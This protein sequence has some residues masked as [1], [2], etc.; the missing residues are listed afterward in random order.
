M[1]PRL[2]GS[3]VFS[4]G[5]LRIAL[6]LA[7]VCSLALPA[8]AMAAMILPSDPAPVTPQ[9]DLNDVRGPVGVSLP[10]RTPLRS[11]ASGDNRVDSLL[12][13]SMLNA[14][15]PLTSVKTITYSFY[16]DDVFHGAYYGDETGVREVSEGV[17][18]NV[19]AIF[20]WYSSI[21]NVDYVEVAETS[22]VVGNFRIMLS[23]GSVSE[24]IGYAY[25]Y[26]PWSSDPFSRSSDVHLN[27]EF[28]Y[29]DADNTNGFQNPAGSHG[30][31]SLAHEI[32][33]GMGLKH[34]FSGSP[35]L[36]TADDNTA[37]TIMSYSFVGWPSSTPM[38]YDVAALQRMY[39]ARVK[40]AGDD[41]YGFTSVGT[42]QYTLGLDTWQNSPNL[43]KQTIWDSAGFDTLDASALPL[44]A[45]GYKFDLNGGG[46][47]V[48]QAIET[49][50]TATDP[51]PGK[52]YFWHGSSLAFAFAPERIVNSS[53]NDRIIANDSANTF[54]GYTAGTSVGNDRIE[55]ASSADKLDLTAYSE[56]AVSKTTNG[57]DLV[58]GLGA[59]GSV[60]LVDYYNGSMPAIKYSGAAANQV[61][62]ARISSSAT[63]GVASL[64]VSFDGS[65]S[66]DPDGSIQ[67]WAWSFSDGTS[68]S[69]V[70]T[71]KAYA[72]SGSYTATLTV[73]DNDGAKAS[74]ATIISVIQPSGTLA[75]MI[76]SSGLPLSGVT[77]SVAGRT[78]TTDGLGAYSVGSIPA[79]T[80][81]VTFAKSGYATQ[82]ASV[83]ISHLQTTTRSVSLVL[84]IGTLSG[85][86]KY[87]T[88]PVEGVSV[89][90]A[91]LTTSTAADG[92]YSI[93]SIPK[94]ASAAT[95][96]KTGYVT[97]T[98]TVTISTGAIL[99][100]NV[101]LSHEVGVLSGTVTSGGQPVAG[102]SVSVPGK[103]SVFTN[104]SGVYTITG[105]NTGSY[106]ATFTKSG[107]ATQGPAAV[108]NANQTT[109]INISLVPETGTLA[110]TVTSGGL[111]LS[112]VLVSVAGLITNTGV[113]GTYSVTSI[114]AGSYTVIFAKSGYVTQSKSVFIAPSGVLNTSANLVR[115]VPAASVVRSPAKSTATYSRKAG[116]AKFTL[117]AVVKGWSARPVA[118]RYI[119]LQTSKN[120]RAWAS[121]YK[122]KTSSAGKASKALAVKAKQVRYYRWYVPANAG[123]NLKTYSAKT[124]VTVK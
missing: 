68:A 119:Y 74:A 38:A 34:P 102:V 54:A 4:A 82:T 52:H 86:V 9:F 12:S 2:P 105:V 26:L 77:V 39:G 69:G 42:G 112:S 10:Q 70:T 108:I 57:T 101:Y 84:E 110:G 97:Q 18:T 1:V 36:P 121:A 40:N 13:G 19:R 106:M 120:G 45:A 124:K 95:Y 65:T 89:S 8:S 59:L 35:V 3:G 7:F 81:P 31:M 96:S 23:S 78:A 51:D 113:D 21:M 83:T 88:V 47:L 37:N 103:L 66:T 73:T 85:T 33:H 64:T 60:T 32:G 17:K 90:V 25:C 41:T 53:S 5:V 79:G 14:L 72:A 16:E 80:Y 107:Y 117:S 114:A 91:G 58:L 75:G 43:T 92:T 15:G 6:T 87:G 104:S 11:L 24:P 71:S 118:R 122:L 55:G 98:S 22:S 28:D 123:V 20:A 76:T 100:K 44:K 56:A 93:S 111:P 29:L 48:N 109:T 99:T 67:S 116:V 115:K 94:G 27:P 46:W 49:T 62:T 50:D 30:Y 63:S 61:P